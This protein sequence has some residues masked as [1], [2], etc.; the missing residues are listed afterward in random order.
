M[1]LTTAEFKN[2]WSRISTPPVCLRGADKD[3]FAPLPLPYD[4]H[5][6]LWLQV[7]VSFLDRHYRIPLEI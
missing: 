7:F 6:I 4:F 2:E 1:K 3:K 5:Y